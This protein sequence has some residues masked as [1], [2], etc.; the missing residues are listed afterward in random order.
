[1]IRYTE[2]QLDAMTREDVRK[3]AAQIHVGDGRSSKVNLISMILSHYQKLDDAE[4]RSAALRAKAEQ[5]AAMAKERAERRAQ[6]PDFDWK[7]IWCDDED[8]EDVRYAMRSAK[9]AV[10][11]W[12]ETLEAHQAKVA[13]NPVFA[14]GWSGSF[15]EAAAEYKVAKLLLAEWFQG[16]SVADLTEEC[17]LNTLRFAREGSSRS[18]STMSNLMDDLQRKAWTCFYEKL[19]GR[20]MF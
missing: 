3:V 14:L 18:T 8:K 1:M 6:N 20:R 10:D 4:Q 7:S 2:N 11:E 9:K 5:L 16:A 15:M 17:L 13:K 19:S 12:A